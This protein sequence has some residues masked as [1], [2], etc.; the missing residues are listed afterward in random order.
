MLSETPNVRTQARRIYYA[1]RNR[2]LMGQVEPLAKLKIS[3]LAE[4]FRVSPGAVREALSRLTTNNLVEARD[5][6]G[7]RVAPI[8]TAEL[9]DLTSTRITIESLALAQSIERGDE[10]WEAALRSAHRALL[11]HTP[12]GHDPQSVLVH[13]RFHEALVAGCGSPALLRIRH[14]L[15]DLA[16]RYRMLALRRSPDWGPED[17]EHGTIVAAALARRTEPAVEALAEHIRRTAKQIRNAM[18][19]RR[20]APVRSLGSRDADGPRDI[21]PREA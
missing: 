18:T 9:S 17:D 15:F 1:L 8:S 6:Q 10:A 2:I 12:R 19:A 3:L 14:E 5:Q 20:V 7:F 11:E 4:E 13:S 21:G 16:D